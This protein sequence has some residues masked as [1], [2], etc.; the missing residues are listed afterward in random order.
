MTDLDFNSFFERVTKL[1]PI[2]KQIQL[3]N[4]LGVGR[5]AISIAKQK[6]SVPYKWVI[7]IAEK[8]NLNPTYLITGKGDP[9]SGVQSG[10]KMIQLT[11]LCENNE[12]EGSGEVSVAF[13]EGV[14][15]FISPCNKKFYFKLEDNSMVTTFYPG[16]ILI[17]DKSKEINLGHVFVFKLLKYKKT[18]F[19]VR[20][21]GLG[22]NSLI[23][24]AD[25][26]NYPPVP[27]D[28]NKFEVIG[29]VVGF[30]RTI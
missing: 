23:L 26:V 13:S 16:D 21:I 10:P 15:I 27:Y 28:S 5:A 7:H 11:P 17:V 3:A 22:E 30:F 18:S 25:N 19:F 9:Y 4:E 29:R 1:T 2:K 20:R 8:Y 24:L 12:D 14:E 6:N